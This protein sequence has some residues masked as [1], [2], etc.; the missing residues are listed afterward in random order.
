MAETITY[1]YS[2]PTN[3]VW[4]KL[5]N[6]GD[7]IKI[8]IVSEPIKYQADFQGKT[9]EK[10]AWLV[11]DR[12]SPEDALSPIKIFNCGKQIWDAIRNLSK[13]PDWGDPMT[14][15]ITITRNGT[16]PSNFYSVSPSPS[17]KGP[18][19]AEEMALVMA[20]EIDLATAV[21]KKD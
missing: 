19:T 4:L 16:S 20:C 7:Q 17:N 5:K 14:F 3:S 10:Y 2:P 18:I 15:D 9:V 8:R 13:D 21:E 12:N 11:I 6:N 1:D